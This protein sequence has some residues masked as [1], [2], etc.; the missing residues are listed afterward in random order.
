MNEKLGTEFVSKIVPV[1]SLA[2]AEWSTN[3]IISS[4]S[5]VSSL[6]W[7]AL[8]TSSSHR[9]KAVVTIVPASVWHAQFFVPVIETGP[10]EFASSISKSYAVPLG[11]K[12][13]VQVFPVQE[14]PIAPGA[15]SITEYG[16]PVPPLKSK[17]TK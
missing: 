13:L 3:I 9:F 5:N 7:V 10:Q 4:K 11:I 8:A 16:P 12:L 2:G 6:L 15:F 14:P 17:L 1:K